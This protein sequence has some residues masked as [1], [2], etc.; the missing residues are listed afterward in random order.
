MC[1]WLSQANK[2]GRQILLSFNNVKLL[3][4]FGLLFPVCCLAEEKPSEDNAGTVTFE[5]A[6]TDK[7]ITRIYPIEPMGI[8]CRLPLNKSIKTFF[9]DAGVSFPEGSYIVFEP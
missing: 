5:S 7:L 6:D 4:V 3:V 1:T 9:E 8:M 2:V